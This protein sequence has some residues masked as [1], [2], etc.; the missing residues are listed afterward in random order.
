MRDCVWIHGKTAE[1]RW[2]ENR[3]CSCNGEIKSISV[4]FV[5]ERQISKSRTITLDEIV[6]EKCNSAIGSKFGSGD[7]NALLPVDE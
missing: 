5:S 7:Y 1:I 4:Y 2:N 6:T 3:T